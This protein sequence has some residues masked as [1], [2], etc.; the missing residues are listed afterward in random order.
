[1]TGSIRKSVNQTMRSFLNRSSVKVENAKPPLPTPSGPFAGTFWLCGPVLP[2]STIVVMNNYPRT[3]IS[4][5]HFSLSFSPALSRTRGGSR[6][7]DAEA[8]MSPAPQSPPSNLR[9]ND[10]VASGSLD[11]FI[12]RFCSLSVSTKTRRTH[13]PARVTFFGRRKLSPL[14]PENFG[15]ENG[16]PGKSTRG[17]RTLSLPRIPWHS[18]PSQRSIQGGFPA[19]FLL[20]PCKVQKIFVKK[21]TDPC[22]TH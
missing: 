21:G 9:Q 15:G 5:R 4:S 7:Q 12:G 10:F 2:H 3:Y 14:F 17:K 22:R 16:S 8:G 20:R 19:F 11:F 13:S 6:F 1:M 18:I